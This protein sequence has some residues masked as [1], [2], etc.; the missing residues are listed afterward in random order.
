MSEESA[1]RRSAVSMTV[2]VVE[3]EEV[4]RKLCSE[5]AE[6]CG[7]K[8]IAAASVS[9]ALEL[10]EVHSVDLV[11]T[12]LKLPSSSGLDL[13]KRVR[14][15]Y[16]QVAVVVLTQYGTIDSAVEA[17]R[18]GAADYVT[19]PFHVED[20]Q[21]RLMRV[22]R[23]A[24]LRRENQLLREQLRTRPGFGGLIGVSERMQ[25][26]YKMIE[27]VSQHEYPVLILGESGTGKE[28]VARSI[29]F[30]GGRK[31]RPF[32]PVD[33]S[34]LVPTL[35][36]SELFGYVKGAFTGAVQAKKGLL[37]SAQ[38]GTLFLDEIGDLP[39]DLQ[40]K[41]LRVLQEREV[42]PVGSTERRHIDVR[43]IAAT[44]RDLEAAIRN[45]SFRQDLYFRLN[46]VQIK[47]PPLRERKS[48]IPLLVTSFLDKFTD[49]QVPARTISEDAMRRLV[50]YDWPGNVRELENAVERAVAL[51][52]GPIVHVGDLPSS[53]QYPSSE[54]APEKE[55]LL[56]LEELERRAILRM[57]RE[58]GGD[59]LA[60]AR[61]LG[62]GKTTLYRKLKQY[63][64][65]HIEQ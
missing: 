50:A 3:D 9:D 54:R 43:I 37:E 23:D 4:T 22:A 29:H 45:G 51:G 58:T 10:L 19:K 56:P 40:A 62:I 32:T 24:D 13:L 47:L 35:I 44:N 28:L 31:S 46:V 60:A 57:L 33:C 65:E 1:A 42:K 64:M 18:M 2:L 59:K 52:S 30:L 63:N 55:E 39:V 5:V 16:P 26:V 48:D 7:M 12:D 49:P 6:S 25:R 8:V 21:T 11:L 14:D 61:M 38:G 20:L 41:L 36:E 15:A 27:K 34:A 53:L 17:T